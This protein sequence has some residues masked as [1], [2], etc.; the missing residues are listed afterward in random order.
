MSA[1]R[2]TAPGV[3]PLAGNRGSGLQDEEALQHGRVRDGEFLGVDDDRLAIGAP[4]E[5]VEIDR[6]VAPMDVPVPPEARLDR[7]QLPK[8]GL[9]RDGRPTDERSVEKGAVRGGA[10]RSGLDPRGDGAHRT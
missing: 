2:T 7:Q 1:E 4:Q 5:E 9:R 6:A 3:V 10:D 8:T